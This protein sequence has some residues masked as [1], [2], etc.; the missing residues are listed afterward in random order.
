MTSAGPN[1]IYNTDGGTVIALDAATGRPAWEYRYPRNERPT[2]PRY[3]DLCPPLADGGRVYA[4]P[5]DTD[6]LLCLDA[7]TGRLI[8]EREGVEVIHLLGVA[9]GRLI[10]TFAG[11][12]R[13]IRGLNLWT[14]ADSGS[15]GWTIHDDGGEGT[16]GRGLVTDDVVVWPTRH[17]LRFLDP[18]DG[19]QLRSPIPGPSRRAPAGAELPTD[20]GPFGNLCYADGVLVVTTATEVW[21]FVSEA[22]KLGDRRKAVEDDPANPATH[23]D[24]RGRSSTPAGTR[25]PRRRPPRPATRRTGCGGS[26]PKGD[27]R[28]SAER[29]RRLYG[30]LAKGDGSFA[31][32]GAARLAEMG[33]ED[34]WRSVAARHGTVRDDRGSRGRRGS[35]RTAR[36]PWVRQR[37]GTHGTPTPVRSRTKCD[38]NRDRSQSIR[39]G[40]R[41]PADVTTPWRPDYRA[42]QPILASL[43]RPPLP[44]A[45]G[46][47][48][49]PASHVRATSE[50]ASFVDA[51]AVLVQS[52]P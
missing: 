38:S 28:R 25:K 51:A 22:K 26:W 6:R 4:A 33:T 2:L 10:A 52:L 11:V 1:V 47:D 13:G 24:R 21:G 40:D 20:P 31:A 49:P 29:R 50:S 15:G 12:R 34:G 36:V 45:S 44:A 8:W 35:S 16:F 18:A 3:R 46:A 9:H 19:T 30:E 48:G 39:G 42:D 23:A 32:A 37:T 14:G 43:L 41:G 5:A 7:A 27:P 17:G